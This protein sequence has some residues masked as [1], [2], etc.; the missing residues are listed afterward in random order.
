MKYKLL[1][2]SLAIT[3]TSFGKNVLEA[4]PAQFSQPEQNRVRSVQKKPKVYRN[5][6]AVERKY[7]SFCYGGRYPVPLDSMPEGKFVRAVIDGDLETVDAMLD[8]GFDIDKVILFYNGKTDRL[9]RVS[10][11]DPGRIVRNFSS[12]RFKH[13]GS[14]TLD[15]KDAELYGTP[16]MV[17]ARIGNSKMVSH[18]LGRGANPNI[19]IETKFNFTRGCLLSPLSFNVRNQIYALKEAYWPAI[20]AIYERKD[21]VFVKKVFSRCD[22]IARMLVDAGAMLAPEDRAGRTALYDAFEAMSTYLLE[23]GVKSGLDPLAEDNTGKNFVEFLQDLCA[24]HDNYENYEN[25]VRVFLDTLR[26]NGVA[27]PADAERL[28]MPDNAD[29]ADDDPS[30]RPVK[31]KR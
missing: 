8:A 20:S 23:L 7:Q 11:F 2:L 16:L 27:L 9:F 29:S 24:R 12:Y 15:S 18:L 1:L 25:L 28:V 17:A 13:G 3:M 31:I 26:K 4:F 10:E 21:E 22:R 14:A 5:I 6:K 30:F 19:F